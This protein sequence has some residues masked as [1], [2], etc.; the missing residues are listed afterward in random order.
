[1]FDEI[2]A[3]QKQLR[4]KRRRHLLYSNLILVTAICIVILWIFMALR[5]ANAIQLKCGS[6]WAICAERGKGPGTKFD[7]AKTV[8]GNQ[9]QIREGFDR[10]R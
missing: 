6:S 5:P 7:P 2:L 4:A 9:R 1:M 8:R 10:P 3:L